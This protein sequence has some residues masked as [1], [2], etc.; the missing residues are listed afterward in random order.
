MARRASSSVPFGKIAASIGSIVALMIGGY[1]SFSKSD[2]YRTTS[3]FPLRDY[4]E[5]ANSLRGNT[6]QIEAVIDKTLSFSQQTGRL[7]AVEALNG[8]MLPILVPKTLNTNLERG[9]KMLFQVTVGENGLVTAS[10][11]RKL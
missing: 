5:N 9:Q 6:Y 11:A 4:L 1:L 2:S 3:S 10:E 8:D 7:I